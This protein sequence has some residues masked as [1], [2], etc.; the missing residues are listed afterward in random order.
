MCEPT[1]LIA[2]TT[3]ALTAASGIAS[4]AGQYSSARAA[5]EAK[6]NDYKRQLRIREIEW[7]RSLADYGNRLTE[8]EEQLDENFLAASRGY[9]AEQSQL[10]DIFNQASVSLQND[11]VKM[12]ESQK[13]Y[14][15]G[16]TARRLG[17]RELAAFGR[18]QALTASNLVRATEAYSQD[19]SRIRSQLKAANRKTFAPVQFKPIPGLPP[20]KPD[21]DMTGANL[22][23]FGNLTSTASSALGT[24]TEL[25]G[26]FPWEKKTTYTPNT[27]Q[28]A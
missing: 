10:N 2:A 5:N 7:D 9:A 6:V 15:E 1:T 20:V 12:M 4:A 14:G 25:G 23:V 16:V 13:Y 27:G 3:T 19:V 17:S 11:F 21:V 28:A 22:Q 24:Y 26:S 8:A 18:S